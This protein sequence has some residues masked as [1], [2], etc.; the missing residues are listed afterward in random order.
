MNYKEDSYA[1][2]LNNDDDNGRADDES[3]FVWDQSGSENSGLE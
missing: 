2:T 1:D 3:M